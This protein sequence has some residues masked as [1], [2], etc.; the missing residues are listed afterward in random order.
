MRA[1]WSRL[2]VAETNRRIAMGMDRLGRL[3][4]WLKWPAIFT[5]LALSASSLLTLV[6]SLLPPWPPE[7]SRLPL[8]LLLSFLRINAAYVLA[9]LWIVPLALWVSDHP[10]ALRPLTLIAQVGA[11]V[12]AT[13]FF[14]VLVALLVDRFGGMEAI[15]ILLALTG[16]QSYLLFNV[17][18]GVQRVPPDLRESM[19]SLGLSR[20]EIHRRLVL[21]ACMPALVTGSVVAWGGTWNALVLSEYVVYRHRTYEVVGVGAMLNEATFGS[22]DRTLL[23]LSVAVLVITVVTFNRLVWKRVFDFVHD[24]YRLEVA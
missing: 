17:L 14:P 1:L 15:S 20:R 12:P 10:K 6:S 18:A 16:M 21:P 24:R 2:P 13:A 19:R 5:A 23:L 8:A 7:A 11:S 22:G 9:L 4:R 3:W